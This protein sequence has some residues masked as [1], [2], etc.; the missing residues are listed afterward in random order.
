LARAREDS[1][2][3]GQLL[4]YL[5]SSTPEVRLRAID[6]VRSR[7]GADSLVPVQVQHLVAGV[8]AQVEST[9]VNFRDR[10]NNNLVAQAAELID[11][12][13]KVDPRLAASVQGLPARVYIQVP[14]NEPRLGDA[15]RT[16]LVKA[17]FLVPSID[18]SRRLPD[19]NELRYYVDQ[20]AVAARR[21]AEIARRGGFDVVVK[22]VGGV[23]VVPKPGT[24][25]LWLV[26]RTTPPGFDASLSLGTTSSDCE[27]RPEESTY[28]SNDVPGMD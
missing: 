11:H 12:S 17:S 14:P 3:L 6:I 10:V 8:L 22:K 19:Q 7:Y 2:F 5:T 1:E 15:L 27:S 28:F 25:E 20:D 4:P 13:G 24:I 9:G 16:T 21:V 26:R 18:Q 23:A